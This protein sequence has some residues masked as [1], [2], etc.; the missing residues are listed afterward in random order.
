M[1]LGGDLNARCGANGGPVTGTTGR[2]DEVLCYACVVYVEHGWDDDRKVLEGGNGAAELWCEGNQKN[3]SRRPSLNC[4]TPA[5]NL[6]RWGGCRLVCLTIGPWCA[7]AHGRPKGT[8]RPTLLP[9]REVWKVNEMSRDWNLQLYD[10]VTWR[11]CDGRRLQCKCRGIPHAVE[12]VLTT[13]RSG[14]GGVT[15]SLRRQPN[16]WSA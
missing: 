13:I 14:D 9:A 11:W 1:I 5:A 15:S 16:L 2:S 12:R 8:R 10:T 4:A 7:P 6:C 3:N